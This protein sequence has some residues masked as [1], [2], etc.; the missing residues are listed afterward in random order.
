MI[1]LLEEGKTFQ[2]KN[3]FKE[4]LIV[5]K[6]IALLWKKFNY[7]KYKSDVK[8]HVKILEAFLFGAR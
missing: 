8:L 7:S 4:V 1:Q 3:L 5:I 2:K 6:E